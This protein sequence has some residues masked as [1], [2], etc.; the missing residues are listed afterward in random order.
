MVTLPGLSTVRT[1]VLLLSDW[2][3]RVMLGALNLYM[4]FINLFLFLLRFMGNKE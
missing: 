1:R 4:D 2:L 3:T